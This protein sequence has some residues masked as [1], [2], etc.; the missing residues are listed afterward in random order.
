[1]GLPGVVAVNEQAPARSARTVAGAATAQTRGVADRQVTA[2]PDREARGSD[3][4]PPTR[5]AVTAAASR[6]A[7]SSSGSDHT[8]TSSSPTGTTWPS[9]SVSTSVAARVACPAPGR[10]RSECAGPHAFAQRA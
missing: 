5:S 2:S 7:S 4:E 6:S 9:P 1:M 3:A 10:E 8:S